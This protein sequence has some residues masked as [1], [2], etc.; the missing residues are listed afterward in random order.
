MTEYKVTLADNGYI[1]EYSTSDRP[2]VDV[3]QVDEHEYENQTIPTEM[4]REM[5]ADLIMGI[6]QGISS[7]FT[8]KIDV[9]PQPNTD[10]L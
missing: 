3:Y 9:E 8:V 10:E 4:M 6:Q 2:W 5:L 7:E 1:V